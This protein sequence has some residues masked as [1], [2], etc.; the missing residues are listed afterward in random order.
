MNN[1]K[2][3]SSESYYQKHIAILQT[4]SIILVV[5]GHSLHLHPS[6]INGDGL[7]INRM[8]HSFRMPTFLFVSGYLMVTTTFL[9]NKNITPYSFFKNKFKRL[10]IPFIF[11]TTITY[12]PRAILSNLADD[13]ISINWESFIRSFFYMDS[14]PIPLYWFLHTS[15]T[16]L[17]TIYLILYYSKVKGA[18]QKTT[19]LLL[20]IVFGSCAIIQ[21]SITSFF[22][23]Y[24]TIHLGLYFI[25]GAYFAYYSNINNLIIKYAGLLTIIFT[26]LWSISFFMCERSDIRLVTSIFG[27]AMCY[28]LSIFIVKHDY[29]I[30]DKIIGYNYIIF[31]LSWFC[32]V[33]SQQVLSHYISLPWY[34]YTILSLTTGIYIPIAINK[35]INTRSTKISQSLLFLLGQKHK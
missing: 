11:L 22:S 30:F 17:T 26:I 14:M 13:T 31:L 33:L 15:F 2:S 1:L 20:T 5:F 18:G 3:N 29:Q 23:L 32:T 35:L 9:R 6:E 8:M 4:I 7:L 21:P 25:L 27:I 34:C 24:Y 28:S 16:L 10:L 19:L 12:I